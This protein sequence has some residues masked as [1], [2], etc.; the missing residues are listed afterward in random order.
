MPEVVSEENFHGT[1][2]PWQV[3]VD[4]CI[5][6]VVLDVDYSCVYTVCMYTVTSML[7]LHRGSPIMICKVFSE[8][9]YAG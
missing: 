2:L 7:V 8:G 6:L 3:K 5:R 9:G 1:I 4:Y